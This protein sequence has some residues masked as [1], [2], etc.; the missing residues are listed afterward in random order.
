MKITA[1]LIFEVSPEMKEAIIDEAHR[2][3]T[4]QVGLFRLMWEERQEEKRKKQDK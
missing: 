4:T 3:K 1:K 2:L